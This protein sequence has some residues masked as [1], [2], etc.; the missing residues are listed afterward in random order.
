M[1][2][3][4]EILLTSRVACSYNLIMQRHARIDAPGAGHHLMVRGITRIAIFFDSLDRDRY[5]AHTK[6]HGRPLTGYAVSFNKRHKRS[7]Y[8]Q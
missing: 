4:Y 7:G 6:H 1:P 3:N 5:H 8:D 2:I